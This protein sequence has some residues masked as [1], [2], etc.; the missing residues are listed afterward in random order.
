MDLPAH[1]KPRIAVTVGD[2][3]GIGPEVVQLALRS[4]KLDP[5]AVFEVL[6]DDGAARPGQPT[7][8]GAYTALTALDTAAS[9]ALE[10]RFDA[11][12]TGPIHKSLMRAAGFE[13]PGQTEFFARR[14]DASEHCMCLTGGNLTVALV[15]AHVSLRKVPELL[16][17]EAVVRTSRLL[18]RFLKLRL[19]RRPRLAVAGL[20]PH[21]GESGLFGG[22][23]EE[24]ITPGIRLLAEE[25]DIEVGGPYPPDTL[26][27]RA[28]SGEFDGVVCMYHDQGLIPLKLHAFHGGVNVT[29][30][31]PF[32][33]TSPD[34]GTAF[35]LAARGGADPGSMLCALNLA[36]ELARKR[37][38][39]WVE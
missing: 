14:W 27:H 6:G 30:G 39:T 23:E 7:P 13:F 33:R 15:T 31:L 10:G 26:F 17:A 9:G 19:G 5:E 36:A 4:P 37:L 8:E 18:G 38:G 2:P 3:A 29:L 16:T 20:N 34:H 28:V 32:P 25:T 12:V 21:A 22:E 24:I 11:V 1:P 35:E